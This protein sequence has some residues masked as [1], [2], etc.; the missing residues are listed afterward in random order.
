MHKP[1]SRTTDTL[2]IHYSPFVRMAATA[3]LAL[4]A[5]WVGYLAFVGL[6]SGHVLLLLFGAF[7]FV[8]GLGLLLPFV[9]PVLHAWGH[10]GPVLTLDQTGITDV[11]KTCSY[12]PWSDVGL[13]NL[14]VGERASFLCIEFRRPDRE[15]EDAPRLLGLG[16]ILKLAS[17]LSDWNVS[18]R[19][20]ACNKQEVLAAARRLHQRSIRQQV[21]ALNRGSSHGWSGTL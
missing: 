12:I 15:R 20:L 1:R 16:R 19:M 14:G 9:G 13:I 8:V 10:K 6:F 11:R 2:Q 18:L 3:L 17:S 5:G 7:A 21:V 4:V